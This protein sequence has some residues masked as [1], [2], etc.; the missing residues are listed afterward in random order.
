MPSTSPGARALGAVRDQ[1][2][3]TARA[4]PDP[5]AKKRLER[6]RES[7]DYLSKWTA[8]GPRGL[9]HEGAGCEAPRAETGEVATA[10]LGPR[11][12]APLCPG[13]LKVSGQ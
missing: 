6:R 11:R 2:L 12:E 3:G 13:G 1:D 4:A 10:G 7:A 5:S 8:A 9:K